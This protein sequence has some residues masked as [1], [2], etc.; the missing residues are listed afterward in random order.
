[1]IRRGKSHEDAE[2]KGRAQHSREPWRQSVGLLSVTFEWS[3]SQS[4]TCDTAGHLSHYDR[5]LLTRTRFP[6][7]H[8]DPDQHSCPG[9]DD[10]FDQTKA[11][12]VPSV[13]WRRD[14]RRSNA[15]LRSTFT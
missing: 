13:I 1:M 7:T 4:V 11:Q 12:N 10:Q 14:H 9:Q 6:S 15:Y 5:R 3:I 8:V 2:V